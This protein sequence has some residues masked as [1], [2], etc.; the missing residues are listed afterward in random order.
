MVLP[1]YN[2]STIP[3]YPNYFLGADSG[4][5]CDTLQLGITSKYL[6]KSREK[7]NISPNPTSENI[8]ITFSPSDKSRGME[9]INVNGKV[10]LKSSI[11]Q[12]SQAHQVDISQLNEG[13]YLCRFIGTDWVSVKFVVSK[14]K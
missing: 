4:S 7:L 10:V 8:H 12:W 2:A 5:V 11:P 13:I 14:G 6:Y 3:N 1:T 9:I